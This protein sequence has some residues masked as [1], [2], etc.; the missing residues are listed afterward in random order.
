M[1]KTAPLVEQEQSVTAPPLDL[2]VA[3]DLLQRCLYQRDEEQVYSGPVTALSV[4]ETRSKVALDLFQRCLCQRHEARLLWACYSAVCARET[5]QDCFGPVP[6]LSVPETRS[7]VALDLLQR[8]LCQRDE[9][10]VYSGSVTALSVTETRS[11]VALDLFQSCNPDLSACGAASCYSSPMTYLVLTDSSQLRADGFE[12]LPDQIMY[13]CA[14]PYD[15]EKHLANALVVLSSTDEDGEI[16]VRIS[17]GRSHVP[18]ASQLARQSR[19]ERVF[20]PDSQSH[21]PPPEQE[22]DVFHQKDYEWVLGD[23]LAQTAKL[24]LREDKDIRNQTLRQFREWI[25]KNQDL[26]RCCTDGGGSLKDACHQME[27]AV[28]KWRWQPEVRLS[29]VGG[30]SLKCGCHQMEGAA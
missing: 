28:I 11:K 9:E 26:H 10:Q 29:S 27:A 14:E 7:K 24:E 13:P 15:L 12:K 17:V 18:G 20:S 21:Q 22:E 16:K 30:G 23:E 25:N 5:K 6:A 1:G 2:K 8:C 4:P 3:P 19:A